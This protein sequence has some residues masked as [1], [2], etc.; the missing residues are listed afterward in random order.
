MTDRSL[1][2]K[3]LHDV[4][5]FRREA[6]GITIDVA[7]QW[8]NLNFLFHYIFFC[9]LSIFSRTNIKDTVKQYSNL[10]YAIIHF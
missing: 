7:L 5:G 3:P 10:N 9:L 4:V 8:Y 2:Q 6:D 1:V